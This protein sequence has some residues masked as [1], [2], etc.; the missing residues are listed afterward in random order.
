MYFAV[1]LVISVAGLIGYF[2]GLSFL[3]FPWLDFLAIYVAGLLGNFSG[4]VFGYF[5]GWTFWLD[6]WADGY[7]LYR[8]R[9][10]SRL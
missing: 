1:L 3:L 2:S 6:R 5:C 4:W 8:C 10:N 7:S 9:A